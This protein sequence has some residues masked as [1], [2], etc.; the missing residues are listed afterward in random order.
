MF[1]P[2]ACA[3]TL[4][5]ILKYQLVKTV[6]NTSFQFI[7]MIGGVQVVVFCFVLSH[8][9]DLLQCSEIPINRFQNSLR[10]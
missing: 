1:Y 6:L 10:E 5:S 2:F 7:L 3:Y 4:S 8:P 9:Y